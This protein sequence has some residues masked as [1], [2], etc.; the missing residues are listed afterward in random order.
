MSEAIR[1][2]RSLDELDDGF[3]PCALSI[4]NFDGVHAGHRRILR[5]VGEF[6]REN[7]WK[8]SALTFDP[9]PTKVVAPVRVPRLLT[10]PD[11]RCQMMRQEGIQQVLILPFAPEI[12]RLRP[13]EFT[14]EILLGRLGVKVV[15]VGAN[16]R[17]GHGQEG[18]TEQ[19]V[20]L[21]RRYGFL[22]EI[23]P[24]VE[25]RGRMISSSAVRR[26]IQSGDVGVAGRLLERPHFLEG[27]VVPGQGIG[28]AKTV[29]T[30]NLRT[31]AEV[32]PA[33]GVYVTRTF[34]LETGRNWPSVS[35]VGYRPTFAGNDLSIE[36]FLISSF[37]GN[38]PRRIRVE[39]LKRLR[40]ERQFV[41]ATDLRSQ[42]ERDVDR[43]RAYFRRADRWI[44]G[45]PEPALLY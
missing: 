3:G 35:N 41:S 20:E 9:H 15:L 31:A 32:L 12:A 29:P 8:A 30:L 43:A 26:L 27:E 24:P 17:F 45:R 40:E 4:G 13:D 39:F 22:A 11:Q 21:G 38:T 18:D 34:D 33:T 16:F 5:R 10:T 28:T 14:R 7:G 19:L 6:A 23:V 2:F 1:V 36:T 37:D 42:I 44:R 25:L